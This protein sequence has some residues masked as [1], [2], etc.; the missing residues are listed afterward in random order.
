MVSIV[1]DSKLHYNFRLE[2]IDGSYYVGIDYEANG[3]WDNQ[4]EARN[5]IYNDWIVKI[6]PGKGTSDRVK[7]E[8][9]IIC[10][11]L[12][13]IGDFDF[14]DVVF[15]AK[16]WESGKT[17]IDILAAGGKIDVNV[18]GV[19][20]GEVMGKMVNTGLKTVPTYYFVAANKYNSLIDIPIIVSDED[21]AGN[22]TSY[23]LSAE[24][25][26]APQKICV[27][28]GFKWCKEYKSLVDAY[29]G[30]KDW[31]TGA[32]DTWCGEYNSDLVY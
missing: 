28:L 1:Q 16:V 3:Q 21:E 12:G 6:V 24:K 15:Y 9:M 10:E 4:K 19:N 30:F 20:V 7:E 8:G 25:G 18:A 29:P 13:T 27:S 23:A 2:E 32:S 31:T 22:I 11:D 17:E 14:N 26:K 5:Y